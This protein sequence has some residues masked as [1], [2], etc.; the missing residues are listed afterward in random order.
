MT[1]LF[2][3][4]AQMDS[5][6]VARVF[7]GKPR[8]SGHA[9]SVPSSGRREWGGLKPQQLL[10]LRRWGQGGLVRAL[11]PGNRGYEPD[12]SNEGQSAMA[13]QTLRGVNSPSTFGSG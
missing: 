9:E 7:A 4:K 12:F 8:G 13:G 1:L 3:V 10:Q 2:E 5:Q 6:F 11:D